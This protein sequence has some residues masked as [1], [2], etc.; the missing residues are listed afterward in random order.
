MV[1][2]AATPRLPSCSTSAWHGS[3]I[4]S[5][6]PPA[7]PAAAS[8]ARRAYMSPE[9]AEG[10]STDARSDIFSFGAVLYEM[11][12]GGRAFPGDSLA[13]RRC[14]RS[15]AMSR[16]RWWRRRSCSRSSRAVW[17]NCPSAAFSRCARSGW[18]SRGATSSSADVRPSIAVLP[19]ANLSA[20]PENEYFAD[21]L[22]EEI[23]NA[24]AQVDE[25]KVIARTSAFAFKGRNEDIR[26]IARRARRHSRARGQRPAGGG[27]G[28][29]HRAADQP[30]ATAR[31]CTR[32]VSI[33]R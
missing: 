7:R 12:A 30:P 2:R 5:S 26:G 11:L 32:S 17:R 13:P 4:L 21:G 8:S 9:Q 33:G 29:D 27:A 22:A 23:I 14:S 3:P 19:F 31:T 25:L 15:S 16:R 28:P 24:L 20:D 1:L 6:T 10:R 18:R